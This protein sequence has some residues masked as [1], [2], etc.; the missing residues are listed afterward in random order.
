MKKVKS[1][2]TLTTKIWMYSGEKA[3]WHFLTIPKKES[4]EIANTFHAF[5]KGWGSLPVEVKIGRTTWKTS[6]FPDR[7]SGTFLLPVKASVRRAE[8]IFEGDIVAYAI[9]ILV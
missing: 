9:K 1:N 2:Y 3:S 7:K 4:L 6:I 5:K 8:G